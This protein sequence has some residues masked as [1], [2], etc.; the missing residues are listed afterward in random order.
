MEMFH[1]A[2]GPVLSSTVGEELAHVKSL[3][4][5]GQTVPMDYG[6]EFNRDAS[7]CRKKSWEARHPLPEQSLAR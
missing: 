2:S 7:Q 3:F 1:T 5:R 6:V 4:E